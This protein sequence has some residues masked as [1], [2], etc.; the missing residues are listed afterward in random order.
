MRSVEEPTV[1]DHTALRLK[2]EDLSVNQQ[3]QFIALLRWWTHVFAVHE[4]DFGHTTVVKHHNPTGDA[5][6][7]RDRYRPVPPK[8]FAELRELL[9]EMVD[10]KV[11]RESSSP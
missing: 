9:Q 7:I 8:L 1:M 4:N 10:N 5:P 3:A 11:V 2:G 6:P